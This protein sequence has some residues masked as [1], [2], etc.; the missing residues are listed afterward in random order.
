ME[1]QEFERGI[2]VLEA[3]RILLSSVAS[4]SVD[5]SIIWLASTDVQQG[6]I[7]IFHVSFSR[8]M[9]TFQGSLVL[10]KI[11]KYIVIIL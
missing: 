10:L 7:N 11:K 4:Q 1:E 5:G 3:G 2:E 8:E 9:V 6:R